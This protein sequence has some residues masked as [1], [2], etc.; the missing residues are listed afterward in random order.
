M[1]KVLRVNFANFSLKGLLGTVEQYK[2]ENKTYPDQ[3]IMSKDA[4]YNYKYITGNLHANKYSFLKI[5]I[6]ELE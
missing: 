6:K 5:P 4:L 1:K 2:S 3:I